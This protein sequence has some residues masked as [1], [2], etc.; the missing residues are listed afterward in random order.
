MHLNIN[1]KVEVFPTAKEIPIF[2]GR[3]VR[4]D[5]TNKF[6]YI[7][8]KFNTDA[9][10]KIVS[11]HKQEINVSIENVKLVVDLL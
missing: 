6:A 9:Y 8:G 7:S 1:D 10:P 11:F 4:F 5:S 2:R 3:I